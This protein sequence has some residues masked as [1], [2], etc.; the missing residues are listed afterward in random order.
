MLSIFL[1]KLL[2]LY[3]VVVI[4]AVFIN[5]KL[6]ERIVKNFS[7]NLGLIYISGLFNL[8]MGLL[9][10]LS[11]NIWVADWRVLITIMGWLALAKGIA[12]LFFPEKLPKLA[13]KVSESWLIIICTVF[14][15]MGVYLTYAGFLLN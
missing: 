15:I 14:L 7:D 12:R 9:I 3:L 10:V 11:H 6:L 2:G 5:R 8:T 1:A 4:P 13:K